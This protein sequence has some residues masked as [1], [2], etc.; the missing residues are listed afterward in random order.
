MCLHAPKR[1]HVS[2]PL[3]WCASAE[4]SM[5]VAL[6]YHKAKTSNQPQQHEGTLRKFMKSCWWI[7]IYTIRYRQSLCTCDFKTKQYSH[8]Q[9]CDMA[10]VRGY[11][12]CD[13]GLYLNTLTHIPSPTTE[14]Q[15]TKSTNLSMYY[16]NQIFFISQGI[17]HF[18]KHIF[19][20][21]TSSVQ[22]RIQREQTAAAYYLLPCFHLQ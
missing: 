20:C 16:V 7:E 21:L 11:T 3:S 10:N 9:P 18:Y 8:L 22:R 13:P 5:A 4:H 12:P 6:G 1:P 2:S 19:L 14:H 15:A 17:K